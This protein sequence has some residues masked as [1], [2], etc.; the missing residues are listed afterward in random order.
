VVSSVQGRS[1]GCVFLK[2]E[3][4]SLDHLDISDTTLSIAASLDYRSLHASQKTGLRY[5]TYL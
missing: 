1:I 4:P 2:P 3:R 5:V